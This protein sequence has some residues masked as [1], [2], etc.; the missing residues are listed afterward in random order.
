MDD[1]NLQNKKENIQQNL[2][3]YADFFSR[4][5]AF[6]FDSLFFLIPYFILRSII[7]NEKAVDYISTGIFVSYNIILIKKYQQTLGKRIFNLK[8]ESDDPNNPDLKWGRVILRETL[9]KVLSGL[10]LGFGYLYIFFK[11]K[12]Q[13]FHDI[14]AKTVVVETKKPNLSQKILKIFLISLIFI[15]QL[16]KIF[17][18]SKFFYRFHTEEEK[19]NLIESIEENIKILN[20]INTCPE[21]TVFESKLNQIC[22]NEFNT[23]TS[24]CMFNHLDLKKLKLIEK[25]LESAISQCA[26]YR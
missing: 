6:I 12:R 18:I 11:S 13:A 21:K 15:I 3:N 20:H 14:L 17:T 26:Q 19:I 25:E 23:K 4:F 16:I 5:A 22:Q 10:F 7:K 24:R 1:F 2:L 9:G 8:I